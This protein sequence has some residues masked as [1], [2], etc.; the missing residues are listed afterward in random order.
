MGK[1]QFVLNF[2]S[3]LFASAVGLGISFLLTPYIVRTLGA[4]AYGFFPLSANFISYISIATVALN[5]LASR[6]ITIELERKNIDKAN[7][8]FNSVFVANIILSS[9]LLIVCTGF[10]FFLDR[11]F[12]IP[13]NLYVDVRLLFT[14]TF[15]S[16]LIGLV[17]SVFSVCTFAVNRQDAAALRAIISNVLRVS[18][19][20][21]LF[22]FF[23]PKLYYL[24]I[25]SIVSA[26]YL[27][28]ANFRLTKRFLPQMQL[29]IRLFDKKAVKEIL[30]SGVWNSVNQL[31]VVLLTQLDLMLVNIF[32]NA[33]AMGEFSL[34]KI[35]PN[36]IQMLIG[37]VVSVFVPTFVILF[38]Q[39]KTKE[40][41]KE[42]FFSI[43]LVGMFALIPISFLIVYGDSFFRLWV[44]NENTELLHKLSNLALIPMLVTGSI[45]TLFNV[46]TVTNKLK[47]PALV[48]V[49]VGTINTLLVLF[50]FKTTDWGIFVIPIV[51]LATG[52][53]RNL[54]FTPIYAARCLNLKWHTFYR[55]ISKALLGS[56]VV[57][58][59]CYLVKYWFNVIPDSWFDFIILAVSIG[60]ISVVIMVL[61]LLDKQEKQAVLK[62]ISKFKR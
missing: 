27:A 11:I 36:F 33:H 3:T 18:T 57:M 51:G 14:F 29:N 19:I 56:I 26:I 44:P 2:A 5:A 24:G 10:L 37:T 6:F 41:L 28:I 50:A 45:N 17:F 21:G 59:L 55:N 43:K 46:Y 61:I 34:T 42:V 48:W 4:T 22:Y 13:N 8:Y 23:I 16:M 12:D 49:T 54:I 58:S 40:L 52:L 20:F 39:G 60:L 62:R 47:I 9:I 53:L 38:G 15:I 35:I 25:S 1:K 30:S 32:L 7:V 31:S